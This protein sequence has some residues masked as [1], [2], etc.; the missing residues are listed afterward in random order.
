MSLVVSSKNFN[1]DSISRFARRCAIVRPAPTPNC[2]SLFLMRDF[3][4]L[5]LI[6]LCSSSETR[7]FSSFSDM[8][9]ANGANLWDGDAFALDD[10]FVSFV[11]VVEVVGMSNWRRTDEV[12]ARF[13]LRSNTE[14]T[15]VADEG[16]GLK[17]LR[18]EAFRFSCFSFDPQCK[19]LVVAHR[20]CCLTLSS[21]DVFDTETGGTI[22]FSCVL[23]TEVSSSAYWSNPTSQAQGGGLPWSGEIFFFTVEVAERVLANLNAVFRSLT[24]WRSRLTSEDAPSR[25]FFNAV[26]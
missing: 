9:V 16:R 20:F 14:D 7:I 8:S 24:S 21:W 4:K 23:K 25:V 11:V 10:R 22:D 15:D 2:M 5:K 19:L 17:C 6:K 12:D 1:R 26:S 13:S 3:S 18:P